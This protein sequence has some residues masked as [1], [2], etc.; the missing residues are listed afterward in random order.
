MVWQIMYVD[1][2][3]KDHLRS[4]LNEIKFGGANR[5]RGKK[6][7]LKDLYLLTKLIFTNSWNTRRVFKLIEDALQG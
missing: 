4:T 2:V 5:D 1:Y 7:I 6:P 3:Q